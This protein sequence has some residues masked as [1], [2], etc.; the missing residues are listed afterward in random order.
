MILTSSPIDEVCKNVALTQYKYKCGEKALLTLLFLSL[1]TFITFL[2]FFTTSFQ[3][4]IFFSIESRS[5]SDRP[6]TS[7]IYKDTDQVQSLAI[8][9]HRA[10]TQ[11]LA[12]DIKINIG[13]VHYCEWI[14]GHTESVHEICA[15]A[16]I[17]KAEATS[18]GSL[19]G[20]C[21]Q[22]LWLPEHWLLVMSCGL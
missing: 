8:Q 10:T 20:L 2:T 12:D 7:W 9:S 15:K 3:C 6:S 14:L 4:Y 13:L 5:C 17:D 11:D 19:M 22:W 16:V 18:S 21:K 1:L